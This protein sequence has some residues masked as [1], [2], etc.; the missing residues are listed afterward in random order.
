MRNI[1]KNYQRRLLNLS[2]S[3]RALLL[4]RL[5]KEWHLDVQ[6]MDYLIS[7]PAFSIIQ[8]LIIGKKKIVLSP[9]ADSRFAPVAPVS[10]RLRTI[11]R[12][13]EMVLEER[14]SQ[15]LYVGWPF[16]HGQ[17]PDG[18]KVRC[19]LL[20]FPVQLHINIAQEWELRPDDARTAQF[21]QSFLLA[22]AHY[23]QTPLAEP[24]TELDL[25]TLSNHPLEFRTQIYELLKEHQ[26][27]I[28]AGTDFFAEKLR[29]FRDYKKADFEELVKPGQLYLEQ[30]A[31]LGL[32][33][34]AS[35]FLVAD[36]DALLAQ[37]E[38]LQ[39][40]ELFQAPEQSITN[41]TQ[42]QHTFTLFELDASQEVALQEVKAGKSIV[43]Q[44]PPGT[45]KS[46]LICNL[47]SDFTARG[48]KVLV[49]SQKRAALDVVYQRLASKGLGH[50]AAVVHDFNTD[51]KAVYAQ[52]LHQI[53]H[54]DA[55][56]KQNLALNSI[57]TDRTFLE[58]SR[59]IN[60]HLQK[61]EAFKKA[62]FDTSQCGWSAKELY[63][64]SSLKQPFVMLPASFKSLTSDTV[65]AFMPRL[66]HY[67]QL[68]EKLVQANQ[69]LAGRKSMEGFSWQQRHE[70]ESTIQ[71][72][73][74]QYRQVQQRINKLSGFTFTR[75]VLAKYKAA[76]PNLSKLKKEVADEEVVH[77]MQTFSEQKTDL[78]E[79]QQHIRKVRSLYFARQA[80]AI[81]LPE[82]QIREAEKAVRHYEQQFNNF[83]KRLKWS[84]SEEKKALTLVAETYGLELSK[85]GIQKL[86]QHFK[87]QQETE[88]LLQSI[89]KSINRQ[90]NKNI[91]PESL[92]HELAVTEQAMATY[93]L[94]KELHKNQV[95]HEK[96]LLNTDLTQQL[97]ELIQSIHA[98][99]TATAKWEMW[100]TEPQMQQLLEEEEKATAMLA[101]LRQHFELL[102]AFDTL[103][104]SF[105][106]SER[107]IAAQLAGQ[108]IKAE[109]SEQLFINSLYLAWLHELEAQHPVLRI[110]SN[111]EMELL[112]SELQQLLAQKEILTQEIVTSKLREQTYRNL[113]HNRL[114]NPV[115]YRKLQA[116]VSKKRSLYPIRKLFSL[117][118]K[119]MLDLI[120]CWLASPETVSAV[121]PLEKCFDLV[122]FDE[123]SQCFSEVGIPGILRG[124][125]VVVAGDAQQLKPSDLYRT[126]WSTAEDDETEELLAESLLQLCTLYLPQTMLTQHY[127]SLYPELIDFSNKH[128]YNGKL[129]LIPDLKHLQ[130]RK[131]AIRFIPVQGTWQDNTN[132][133]EAQKV[134]ETVFALLQNGQQDIGVITFNYN[135]Q[136]LVQDILEEKAAQQSIVLPPAILVKN[137]ENMQGDERD[138]IILSVGY[139]PDAKGKLAMQFGSLNQ[140]GGENRLNVAISRARKEIVILCSLRPEQ[141]QVE[142]SVHEGPKLLKAYLQ[143]AQE[144]SAGNFSFIP[145][146]A[147]LPGQLPLLKSE[148]E[149]ALP[150]FIPKVPFADLTLLQGESINGLILTD[151][152][153]YYSH[154]S[155]RQSHADVP[156]RLQQRHWPYWKVYS[157][158]FWEDKEALFDS[159]QH[160]ASYKPEV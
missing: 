44:G 5:S 83:F 28:N 146:Q 136:Q 160:M 55:Y 24:L 118:R 124:Q 62:L 14:G 71:H 133:I 107:E 109:E 120:P 41:T 123:A 49:V 8:K 54:L 48:K 40:E 87:E 145:K 34:Q 140:A 79:L 142:N 78:S 66:R 135:Q 112:E 141:L 129:E 63:L 52:L 85:D 98:A 105:T 139:A 37:D 134:A 73:S 149:Q 81:T 7:E 53:T 43:V 119:E 18:T 153:L 101:A 16:V 114:G 69:V 70:L 68:S 45:G 76:I 92:T 80:F 93:T 131:P 117:F 116:Q 115:T 82:D 22:Y 65:A 77:V 108:H 72:F 6:E 38:L 106:D 21:N 104:N 60:Q 100:L 90:L 89:G 156:V 155:V 88:K 13:T 31:V 127:R 143:Y 17:F 29:S 111:G 151:D 132:P 102:V 30:E 137:I 59:S 11:K 121:L 33:P 23:M 35:S 157:R 39:L 147:Q 2:S 26:L 64:R 99:V 61:L 25:S 50:F 125:Q 57:Y 91:S 96:H 47:V 86:R 19:P 103:S 32:F 51:K 20:F 15:E 10:Q 4:L 12:K 27:T 56:K 36:Y 128:F 144:V 126:R 110:P 67:L 159:L 97:Q 84:F 113:E 75:D 130:H 42:A 150:Y 138:V 158:Q 1:L 122:I 148:I 46:Q 74:E 9:L 3:N 154:L 152:D 58:V 94:L 95:F